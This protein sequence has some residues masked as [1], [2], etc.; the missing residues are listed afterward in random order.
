MSKVTGLFASVLAFHL[1]IGPLD[2]AAFE[3]QPTNSG[4]LEYDGFVPISAL[5]CLTIHLAEDRILVGDQP[6][7]SAAEMLQLIAGYGDALSRQGILITTP[8]KRHPGV[9]LRELDDYCRANGID[10]FWECKSSFVSAGEYAVHIIVGN[11]WRTGVPRDGVRYARRTLVTSGPAAE[12][13][14]K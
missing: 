10:L 2:G 8:S 7:A 6:C 3:E 5:D 12:K 14:G 4:R 9:D 11:R 1:A 13:Q